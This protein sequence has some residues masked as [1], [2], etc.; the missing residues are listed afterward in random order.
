MRMKKES[1]V[2]QQTKRTHLTE[3]TTS[4]H[5]GRHGGRDAG[6]NNKR[7]HGDGSHRKG[8]RKAT[9]KA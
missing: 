6:L 9:A 3:E 1:T 8:K 4:K 5:A 2:H 7:H